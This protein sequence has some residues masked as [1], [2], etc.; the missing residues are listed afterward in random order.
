MS[1][2]ATC[3]RC[4]WRGR[5]EAAEALLDSLADEV[6]RD[7]RIRGDADMRSIVIAASCIRNQVEGYKTHRDHGHTADTCPLD[8]TRDWLEFSEILGDLTEPRT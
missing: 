6:I 4:Y 1:H 2:D 3:E 8:Y 7:A 5:A